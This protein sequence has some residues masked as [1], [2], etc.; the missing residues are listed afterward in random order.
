MTEKKVKPLNI[1]AVFAHPDDEAGVIGTLANHADKG[2]NVYVIFLTRGEN[3]SSLCCSPEE[4]IKIRTGHAKEIEKILGAEYRLLDLP[5][6]GVHPSVENANKLAVHF[7]E[8]KPDI[9]ITWTQTPHLGI[10]HPDHRYTY[11]ITLDAISY[12]R[13]KND[14]HKHPPHREPIGLYTNYFAIA[15]PDKPFYVDVSNQYEKIMSVID[16]YIEAY[17]QWPVK[18]YITAQLMMQGRM[19]GVKFAEAYNKILWRTAQ[20]YLY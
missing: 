10:G 18:D 5:D 4:I 15:N 2:D 13:Y 17:G 6:S 12:A 1:V 16:V 14:D 7:K 19:A 20:P 11:N 8:I 9:I 3:A